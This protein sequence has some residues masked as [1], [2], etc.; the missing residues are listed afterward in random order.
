MMKDLVNYE[1]KYKIN[2]S[3]IIINNK[4]HVMRTAVSNS[5]YL[6]TALEQKGTTKRKNESIHR[7][8]AQTFIPNPYNLPVVMHKD[9]DPLNNHVSNL[10]WGNQSEN[11]KQAF[12]EGRKV[13]PAKNRKT[14]YVYEVYNEDTGDIIKCAG[15]S[16][17]SDLI[18]YEEISLKNMVGNNRPI[19]LGDYKG[20]MIRRTNNIVKNAV[21]FCNTFND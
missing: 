17:V 1:G 3:G 5:G 11:I 10:Q 15:R 13:S 9:N 7:L 20:Y 4:G 6:R 14:R 18:G 2:E 12:I 21:N 16:E 19:C 8:V